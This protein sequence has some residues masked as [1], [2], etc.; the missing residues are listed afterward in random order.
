MVIEKLKNLLNEA[1][2]ESKFEIDEKEINIE[3]PREKQFG[4]YSSNIAL[5]LATKLKKSP[6]EIAES[7]KKALPDNDLIKETKIEKPGFINFYLNN[8]FFIDEVSKIAQNNGLKPKA[9]KKE[10]I[11]LEHTTVNPNKGLHIGH[12]RNTCLGDACANILEFLGNDVERHYYA[13]DTGVQV[14][15]TLLGLKNLNLK[16]EKDEKFDHFTQRVYVETVKKLESNKSLEKK[17]LEIIEELDK[18]K[19]KNVVTANELTNKVLQGH[20][21]TTRKL[22]V[23]FDLIVWERDIIKRGFWQKAFEILKKSKRFKQVNSGKNK[24]CWVIKDILYSDK[25]LVKSNGV[26]TYTGKDIAYHL[27]KFNLLGTDFLYAKWP[28]K[29]QKRELYSTDED[30]KESNKFGHAQKVV[31]FIDVR[32][33]YPQQ[34]VKESLSALG[35]ETEAKHLVHIDYGIVFLSKSTAKALGIKISKKTKQYA[36]SGRKGIAILVDDLIELVKEKVKKNHPKSKVANEVAVG[37]IKYQMLKYNTY[38]YLIFDYSEA[39]DLYGDT[40]PYLQYAHARCR[41][42]LKKARNA[43]LNMDNT[44]ENREINEEE[45]DILKHLHLFAQTLQ[46]VGNSYSPNLLCTYLL[47]LAQLFN[48]FYNKHQVISKDNSKSQTNLRLLL[49]KSTGDVL[50]QGLELLGIP[51]PEKM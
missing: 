29:L 34:A 39:L 41:S 16:Q 50:K 40:G 25:I 36:M 28:N 6:L 43:G 32:Q 18:Q 3:K 24:G 21:E 27:W 22:N 15:V 46:E 14:A 47:E 48:T 1:L 42:I 10:K 51:A 44:I 7:I 37:A 45:I 11:I 35:F 8:T 17:E 13:D 31:N 30:G 38:T 19:G 12:L 23:E 5:V 49:V 4:D 20:L 2:I 26:V 33:T 9:R